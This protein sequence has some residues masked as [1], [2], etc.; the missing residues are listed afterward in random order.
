MA[1]IPDDD[2][3]RRHYERVVEGTVDKREGRPCD[4]C[5][6]WLGAGDR[7]FCGSKKRD[8]DAPSL[9]SRFEVCAACNDALLGG[10][11]VSSG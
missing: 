6:G 1:E 10:G 5:Q 2:S 8:S 7:I 9:L 3:I 4:R 11:W